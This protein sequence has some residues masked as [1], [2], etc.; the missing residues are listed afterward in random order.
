M[1]ALRGIRAV[2][3]AQQPNDRIHLNASELDRRK[4]SIDHSSFSY[5][6]YDAH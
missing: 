6:L 4:L 2:D 3:G 5:T 1:Q